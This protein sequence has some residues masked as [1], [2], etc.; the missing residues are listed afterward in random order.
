MARKCEPENRYTSYFDETHKW[1]HQ[2]ALNID[3]LSTT[4]QKKKNKIT[5]TVYTD[6]LRYHTS[7]PA[8]LYISNNFHGIN[9]PRTECLM[10]V[11]YKEIN[12][13]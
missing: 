6:I 1:S 3:N 10:C 12:K 11:F 2:R 7:K 13:V 5:L 9:T 8:N 4:V